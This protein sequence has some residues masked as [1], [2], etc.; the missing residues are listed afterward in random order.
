MKETIKK[1]LP[2]KERAYRL[3]KDKIV[4]CEMM[5]GVDISEEELA[6]ELGSSRTP[7]REA[8]LRLEQE[9]FVTVYPRKG[10]IVSYI[11]N[12]DIHEVFQIREIIEP[13]AAKIVCG[14]ISEEKLI[15]FKERFGQIGLE[16]NLINDTEFF[17]L[18]IEFHKYIVNST[19][20]RFLIEFMN[21]IFNQDYRI[22]VL[23]T[24]LHEYEKKRN[25]PEH[26]EIIDAFM[27]RDEKE[28]EQSI[29]RHIKNAYRAALKIAY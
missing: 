13:Q 3:I 21:K 20:N 27:K 6:K 5:P 24:R 17:E 26:L 19:N 4:T 7:I 25:R 14:N 2:L 9:K 15:D 16:G 28:L 29:L 12:R 10:C 11:T 8:I 18:D 23:A 22:R 1:Q